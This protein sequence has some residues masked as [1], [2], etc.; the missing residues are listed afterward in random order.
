MTIA[1]FRH[2]ALLGER[3]VTPKD[4]FSDQ[5]RTV[6]V[7]LLRYMTVLCMWPNKE[8]RQFALRKITNGM[9]FNLDE[10]EKRDKENT[11]KAKVGTDNVARICSIYI[12]L[13]L[14]LIF[15]ILHTDPFLAK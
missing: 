9:G 4:V 15:Y 6:K 13:L 8:Q 1:I 11:K 5:E 10:M 2:P 3:E 14:L 12:L 7:E